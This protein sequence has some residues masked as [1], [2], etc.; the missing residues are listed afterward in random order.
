MSNFP[1]SLPSISDPSANNFTNSPSHATIHSEVNDE[2]TA[3]ATK[4]GTGAS[5]PVSGT[6]LHGTGAGTSSWDALTI[7]RAFGFSL[8][9]Q[10]IVANDTSW[11]PVSPQALTVLKLW[12]H[13]KTAP[14]GASLIVQ[15]YNITQAKV[16]APVT[17][18]ISGTD[19]N[20]TT[21]T[22][23]AIAAGDVLRLDVTQVGSTVAGADLTLVVECSQP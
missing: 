9:G 1:V 23:A 17:I 6:Y 4:V 5:T 18:A 22:N 2:T 15:I 21:I 16:V 7:N 11:N 13:V 14:T 8:P 20:T 19:A 12:A 10:M 3:I